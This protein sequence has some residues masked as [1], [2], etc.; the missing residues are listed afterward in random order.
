ML[1]VR[2]RTGDKLSPAAAHYATFSYYLACGEDMNTENATYLSILA[3]K[4][5]LV[6]SR[7][8]KHIANFEIADNT[9]IQSY[10]CVSSPYA[11]Q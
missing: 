5:F 10:D 2:P 11:S 4:K 3:T 9:T 6:C 7:P 1:K 8:G